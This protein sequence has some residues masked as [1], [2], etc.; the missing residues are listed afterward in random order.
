LWEFPGGK[1]DAGE[2]AVEALRRELKEELHLQITAEKFLD[3]FTYAYEWGLV[4]LHVFVV[5]ALNEPA[6]SPDVKAFRWLRLDEIDLAT[7][8]PADIAPLRAYMD[9]LRH[10]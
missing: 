7:L 6:L 1:I 5:R 8:A 4:R 9:S 2:S 10:D 3:H